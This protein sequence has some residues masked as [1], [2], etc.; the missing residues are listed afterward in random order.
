MRQVIRYIH[1]GLDLN[2]VNPQTKYTA[3]HQA[4]WYGHTDIVMLLLQHGA[5]PSIKNAYVR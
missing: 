2:F 3:L 1:Q 4:C 5:D